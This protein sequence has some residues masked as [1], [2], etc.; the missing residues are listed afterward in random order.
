[1]AEGIRYQLML[2]WGWGKEEIP[3]NIH[4]NTAAYSWWTRLD[5]NVQSYI[6]PHA[7]SKSNY[8]A[9]LYVS[10]RDSIPLQPLRSYKNRLN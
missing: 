4:L 3:W 9:Q 5:I 7:E 8:D 6:I 10:V 2:S 1:L